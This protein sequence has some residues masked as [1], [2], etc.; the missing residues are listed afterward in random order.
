MIIVL[1][2][3]LP[4]LQTCKRIQI[5]NKFKKKLFTKKYKVLNIKRWIK[6]HLPYFNRCIQF[7]WLSSRLHT[8]FHPFLVSL[9][10]FFWP[11]Y[12]FLDIRLHKFD[13][14][15]L[16]TFAYPLYSNN[17]FT[18]FGKCMTKTSAIETFFQPQNLIINYRFESY[19]HRV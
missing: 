13:W 18:G 1:G 15:I 6:K 19:G 2:I 17:I 5:V 4:Y 11:C 3:T 9:S 8:S 10:R 16:K 12:T 7:P 14:D